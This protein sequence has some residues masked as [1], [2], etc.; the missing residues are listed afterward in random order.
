M[1][2]DFDN[3]QMSAHCESGALVNMLK[4]YHINI[5]EPMVFGIGSGYFFAH[6]PMIKMNYSPV[7]SFRI[8]PGKL[9]SRT[10]RNLG[11]SFES[12]TFNNPQQSMDE[13]DRILDT[14]TPVGLQ[15]GV[16][17]LPYIPQEYRMHYNVHS[18]IVIGKE[19]NEYI[20]ADSVIPGECR[21]SREDLMRVRYAK[22][23]FAP[24]GKMFYPTHVPKEIDF[25]QPVIRGIKKVCHDMLEIP[26]PIIGIKGIRYFSK[27]LR[28]WPLKNG[29]KVAS[30]YLVQTILSLEEIGTGGAGYRY[31]YGAFLSQAADLLGREELKE[32]SI[33]MGKAGNR[34]R[35]FSQMGAKNCKNR[36]VPELTYDAIADIVLDVADKEEKVFRKLKNI[37]L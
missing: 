8:L 36:S 16:F 37:K 3:S 27:K 31:M 34:W 10:C 24:K 15:V 21:I 13:L 30:Q 25:K 20:I 18:M 35:D 19:N 7:T 1:K 11:V 12:R 23:S 29:N 6:L 33:E 28:K 22:G 14:G 26:M 32:V 17:Q 5:T 2:L 9:F 4:Y